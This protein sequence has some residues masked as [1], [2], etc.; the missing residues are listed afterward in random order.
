MKGG[1]TTEGLGWGGVCHTTGIVSLLIMRVRWEDDVGQSRCHPS[2]RIIMS[3]QDEKPVHDQSADEE[4][5]KSLA[6]HESLSEDGDSG[7]DSGEESPLEQIDESP[8]RTD[9]S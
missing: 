2:G 7:S 1:R 5:S 4:L 8:V 3:N 9:N 6:G